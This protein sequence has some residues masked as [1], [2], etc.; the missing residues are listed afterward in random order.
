MALRSCIGCKQVCDKVDLLRIVVVGS[1]VVVDRLKRFPG[2][3]AY[4]H[5]RAS[6]I[7][8]SL[9]VKQLGHRFRCK[10]REIDMSEL[11]VLFADVQVHD[12]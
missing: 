1:K 2:R 11:K 10:G 6:C 7:R 4:L 3:G 12:S 8:K 5:S 9:D